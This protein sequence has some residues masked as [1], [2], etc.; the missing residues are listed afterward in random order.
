MQNLQDLNEIKLDLHSLQ[1]KDA[2]LI[3]Q[4][5]VRIQ[6]FLRQSNQGC[7]DLHIYGTFDDVA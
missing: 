4:P 2:N 1:F 3:K 6:I 5:F 7:S